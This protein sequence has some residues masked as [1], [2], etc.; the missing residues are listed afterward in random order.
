MGGDHEISSTRLVKTELKSLARDRHLEAVLPVIP[1]FDN[2]R[3]AAVP[4]ELWYKLRGKG[5]VLS[6]EP[7]NRHQPVEI[8]IG[9]EYYGRIWLNLE[10]YVTDDIVFLEEFVRSR[11][12]IQNGQYFVQLPWLEPTNLGSNLKQAT[13]RFHRLMKS[14][15]NRGRAEQY[16][17]AIAETIANFA[18][19]APNPP[20]SS[21]VYHLPHHCVVRLDKETT[22]LRVVFDGSAA[23]NGYQ[24]LN[25]CLFKRV[26][27]WSSLD[28]LLSFRLGASAVVADIEKAFLQIKVAE[29]DRDALRF[30]WFDEQGRP[31][32]FTPEQI[33]AIQAAKVAIFSRGSMNVRKWQTNVKELDEKWSPNAAAILK[34]LGHKWSVILDSISLFRRSS[35]SDR[36]LQTNQTTFLFLSSSHL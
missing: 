7:S 20:T 6:D 22:Q 24:F 17:A 4:D 10:R 26:N 32:Q 30:G 28:L 12:S 36:A 14:L 13:D 23:G 27:N 19:L 3:P 33:D 18:E 29:Q 8:I 16:A 11:V 25:D 34:V 31:T 21:N 9:L 15:I 2:F 5:I 35:T 1:S